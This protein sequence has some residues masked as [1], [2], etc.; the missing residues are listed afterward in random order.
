M[1]GYSRDLR[2]KEST[3]VKSVKA[4]KVFVKSVKVH[5]KAVRVLVEQ[6]ECL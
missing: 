4:V 3:F 6:L 1:R 5:V 2:A